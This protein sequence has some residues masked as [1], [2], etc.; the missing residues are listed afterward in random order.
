MLRAL[1]IFIV[2]IAASAGSAAFWAY[3]W[4]QNHSLTLSNPVDFEIKDGATLQSVSNDLI[5]HKL[6]SGVPQLF[7]WGWRVTL[8]KATVKAGDYRFEGTLTPAK[9]AH[10]LALGQTV[11]VT[12]T[13]PEGWNMY[14]IADRLEGVFPRFSKDKW[15]AAMKDP[16]LL[17]TLPGQ[18]ATAEGFLFPETY[19]FNPRVTPHEVLTSLIQTFKKHMTVDLIG[20]GQALNLN[21]LQIVILASIIEKETGKAEER[22]HISSVFHNR[23]RI[24]MKLQTDPTVIYGIWQRYDGNIRKD[25]LRTPTPYNTYVIPG[26]PPGPIASPGIA[27]LK[28]AVAPIDSKD[29]Y[30][31]GK[32]DGSHLFS[33]TL[34]DHQKGVYQFQIAP[35]KSGA[36]RN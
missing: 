17:S 18:P 13:I 4:W 10:A 25:D 8:A 27:S 24:G 15:I 19:T 22:P 32:G 16:K 34:R 23:M 14:Q 29:L 28:A 12:F 3:N 11:T 26:L 21:P 5:K 2:L 31:V 7:E 20:K 6:I 35:S 30:F 33:T 1:A 36:A 9:I